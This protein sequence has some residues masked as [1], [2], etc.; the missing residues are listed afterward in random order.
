MNRL[1]FT[2]A[3]GLACHSAAQTPPVFVET[4]C[5][6]V[7][8]G[9]APAYEAFV[10]DTVAKG[11]R[12]MVQSGDVLWFLFSRSVIPAGESA[13]C[14]Y[15]GATATRGF[16]SEPAQSRLAQA[17]AKAGTNMTADQYV[18][19]LNSLRRQVTNSILVTLG[20]VGEIG[21]GDYYR[22]NFMKLKPGGAWNELEQKIWR[23]VQE[24]RV[25]DGKLKAWRT[26][27]RM[28]PGGSGHPYDAVTIDVFPSWAAQ[29]QPAGLSDVI[30]KVHPTMQ[31]QEFN[32]KTAAARDLVNSELR[33]A[34]IVMGNTK[35]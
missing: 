30:K 26:Y 27:N 20:A 5:L 6:K 19:K 15:V 10:R 14:D 34:I 13:M 2:L 23:P 32:T 25:K 33:R 22:V 7:E 29:G 3:A 28:L 11:M 21:E 16:P 35:M 24:Q 8:A 12:A 4:V 18:A 31:Q 17:V 1:A 9:K